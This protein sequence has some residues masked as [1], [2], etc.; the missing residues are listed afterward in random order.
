MKKIAC[1]FL[2]LMIAGTLPAGAAAGSLEG[3]VYVFSDRYSEQVK[4]PVTGHA[5]HVENAVPGNPW[6]D[7]ES[8]Q[9]AAYALGVEDSQT[10][11]MGVNG[12]LV[13]SFDTGLTD[14]E[15]KDL[16]VL[17]TIYAGEERESVRVEVSDDLSTWYEI[18]NATGGTDGVDMNG[19]V[20]A[21]ASFRY[22]RLTDLGSGPDGVVPGADIDAVC[23]I[24]TV[25]L[26]VSA[27][28]GD[29]EPEDEQDAYWTGS[30]REALWNALNTGSPQPL[31]DA[32]KS[33]F[34][35]QYAADMK[36][37]DWEASDGVSGSFFIRADGTFRAEYRSSFEGETETYLGS[38]AF[39]NVCRLS[40]WVYALEPGEIRWD[41]DE[42]E[43]LVQNQMLF[44]IPGAAENDPGI[45]KYELQ[46]I[47]QQNGLNPTEP[48]PYCFITAFDSSPLWYGQL[49]NA[50]NP[51]A[52]SIP[53]GASAAPAA[54][55]GKWTGPACGQEGNAGNFCIH[56]GAAKPA[57]EWTCPSCGQ[58]HN[59]GN[60][61]IHCGAAKPAA[62]WT[63]PNCGQAGNDG[64]FCPACGT[65]RD[66]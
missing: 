16:F 14:G 65:P 62:E 24:Y 51:A 64:N 44:E 43:F 2:A 1:I 63:C 15:G 9:D 60:F 45:L 18:G 29:T 21:G 31:S 52:G 66:N 4:A 57:E 54:A 40:D 5:A 37:A 23:G 28:P 58:E 3:D 32:E 25:P 41:G 17:E 42:N 26:G 34:F 38:G 7:Y 30:G 27:G 12:T 6:T 36:L 61:C 11:T 59:A 22:V 50:G 13:L 56:C 35:A 10:Y 53:G 20:P 49:Q 8:H 48:V 33:A 55:S 19:K 39:V 47:A 46:N